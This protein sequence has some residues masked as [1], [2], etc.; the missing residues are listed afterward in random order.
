MAQLL[1]AKK[2]HSLVAYSLIP[3][4]Y[5]YDTKEDTLFSDRFQYLSA[6]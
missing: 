3:Y 4:D 5:A 6:H 1:G 2:L